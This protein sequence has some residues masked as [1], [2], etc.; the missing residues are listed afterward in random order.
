VRPDPRKPKSKAENDHGS[1]CV[2]KDCRAK[3]AGKS[4]LFG[5]F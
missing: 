4:S 3:K 2:C 1:A 5:D